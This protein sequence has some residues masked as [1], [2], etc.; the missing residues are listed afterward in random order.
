MST[1]NKVAWH[2]DNV[3]HMCARWLG[4][5]HV[6]DDLPRGL[7]SSADRRRPAY[8]LSFLDCRRELLHGNNHATSGDRHDRKELGQNEHEIDVR[9]S[10]QR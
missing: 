6:I 7:S 4:R 9:Q 2:R 1:A 8:G 10:G 5:L 3:F